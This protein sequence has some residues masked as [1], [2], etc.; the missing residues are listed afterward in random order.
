M[1]V[2]ILFMAFV[3][4]KCEYQDMKW[5]GQRFDVV[6]LGMHR[7]RGMGGVPS[8][9]LGGIFLRSVPFGGYGG[10]VGG[11]G[12]HVLA[13]GVWKSGPAS[14]RVVGKLPERGER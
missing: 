14:E 4:C 8:C 7:W 3:I 11:D 5:L 9:V 2:L 10:P 6:A 13:G 1:C 12:V